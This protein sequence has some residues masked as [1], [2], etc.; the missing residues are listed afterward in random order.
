MFWFKDQSEWFLPLKRSPEI[1]SVQLE[2]SM[3]ERKLVSKEEHVL[4]YRVDS[5]LVFFGIFEL[6]GFWRHEPIR[7][8]F[9]QTVIEVFDWGLKGIEEPCSYREVAVWMPRWIRTK[10]FF[11][12]TLD[13]Q[14]SYCI[15]QNH[16]FN[17]WI[18]HFETE[19]FRLR[20]T[21]KNWIRFVRSNVNFNSVK[22]Q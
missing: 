1:K 14:D 2:T 19:N 17:H 20:P 22:S 11:M 6:W 21:S 9:D 3:E 13:C 16:F 18:S 8:F 4:E 12:E 15:D 10:Q 7:Q 5:M